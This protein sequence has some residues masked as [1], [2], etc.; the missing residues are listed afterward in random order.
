MHIIILEGESS[1]GKTT[2]LRI[3]YDFLKLLDANVESGPNHIEKSDIG[4]FQAVL[5]LKN[6]LIAIFTKGDKQKD[7]NDAIDY[8]EKKKY[9]IKKYAKRNVDVLIIA[10][11][12]K[13]GPLKT[14]K[15]TPVIVEKRFARNKFEEMSLNIGDCLE[16]IIQYA[17]HC[18]TPKK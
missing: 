14:K 3:V 4:D 5:S 2:T 17:Q 7:C 13:F 16:I 15:N 6:K 11:N 9:P 8:Y 10:H 12:S 18:L 1:S